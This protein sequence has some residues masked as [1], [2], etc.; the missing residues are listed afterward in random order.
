LAVCLPIGAEILAIFSYPAIIT[1]IDNPA[2]TII[3]AEIFSK[4]RAPL[5]K[6]SHVLVTK[7]IL[8]G[9]LE[10]LRQI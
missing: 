10:F 9:S 1:K 6:I 5:T 8:R 3:V 4:C 2:T 7:A